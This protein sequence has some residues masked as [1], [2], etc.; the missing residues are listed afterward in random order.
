MDLVR[1][2]IL[3]DLPLLGVEVLEIIYREEVR[4]QCQ[5]F[6]AGQN[7]LPGLYLGSLFQ[8]LDIRVADGFGPLCLIVNPGDLEEERRF[9][10]LLFQ[11]ILMA[12]LLAAGPVETAT[13]FR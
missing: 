9:V 3:E 7:F 5:R 4:Q 11:V 10:L 1:E 6:R 2:L 12:I 8:E 13:L